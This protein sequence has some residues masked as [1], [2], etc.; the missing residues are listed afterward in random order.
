MVVG[1]LGLGWL[2]GWWD[3]LYKQ[4]AAPKPVP[5]VPASTPSAVWGENLYQTKLVG[6]NNQKKVWEIEADH[7]W[8]S[9]DQNII[10]FKNINSGVIFSVKGKRATFKAGWA[11]W[12]KSWSNLYMGGKLVVWVD[13][14]QF[15]TREVVM[16]Y[17]TQELTCEHP[18]KLTGPHTLVRAQK[19]SMKI[20]KE[21]I[22]L[23]G[24]V[25]L[26]QNEDVVTTK[27]LIFNLKT[28][29]YQLI[30]PGGIIINLGKPN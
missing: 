16:R 7:I 28:E 20:D 5:S 9:K 3:E 11:R 29:S 10:Y 15:V 12:E 6:W 4:F 26:T 2:G 21:E 22:K 27:A 13:Q 14:Y 19:M 18:V 24:D 1:V 30:E 17:A 8:Q 23:E 25:R